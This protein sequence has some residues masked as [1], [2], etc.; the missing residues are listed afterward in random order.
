MPVKVYGTGG[1][2]SKKEDYETLQADLAACVK[3]VT[4]LESDNK[5]LKEL[6][7]TPTR[8]NLLKTLCMIGGTELSTS[9]TVTDASAE[10][11]IISNSTSSTGDI[12][13][14]TVTIPKGLYSVLIRAKVSD[15]TSEENIFKM[16]ITDGTTTTTKYI[17]PSMF[18][19]ADTYTTLGTVVESTS[20]T[21][22]V[23]LSVSTVLT[24]QTVC[25]DYL[26][27]TPTM[28]GI[29]SIA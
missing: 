13:S 29:T 26:L 6:V 17:R 12:F 27:V 16:I 1:S 23:A 25:V 21:L 18:K 14:K 22:T 9:A 5:G 28:I 8:E 2:R 3:R 15:T 20:G 10:Y 24:D 7:G 11:S 4:A 19:T